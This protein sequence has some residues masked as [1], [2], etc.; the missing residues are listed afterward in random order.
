MSR[1]S[2]TCLLQV[3]AMKRI[4]SRLLLTFAAISLFSTVS[5][6]QKFYEQTPAAMRWVKKKFRKLSKDE[7]IAQLMIIRAHSNLGPEHVAEVTELIKK[8]NVGGLCFFQGGPVRQALLTNRYQSLAKTPLMISIDAE[9][10]VGMRLDSV[11]SFPRQLMMGATPDAQLIYRFGRVVGEQCKRMGIQ[12]NYAPD[13]DVNNNPLNPV[14]NDRSFGEDKYKVALYGVQYMK[15]LQDIGV[16]ATAKHFPGHGDVSVDSHKDLPVITKSRAQLDDLELYPFIELIKAGVGSIMTA[17]L[18][19]PAIDTTPNLP[20]SLSYRNVT[21]ILRNDLHFTGITFTDALEMQGVAKYFPKGDASVLSLIA[22]NDMLCLPGDIPGSIAK[23]KE[24][25]AE[26]KLSWDDIDARVKKVLLAKYHLG[27]AAWEP[28]KTENLVDDLNAQTNAIRQQVSETAL[29]LLSKQNP[30]IFPIQ[31]GRKIAYVSIGSA[32]ENTITARMRSEYGADVYLFGSKA[33]LGAQLMD[34]RTVVVSADKVDTA[35][36]MQLLNTL[37]GKNYDAVIVGL[38]NYSRRPANNYGLS[39]AVVYLVN[40]LQQPNMLTMVFGNPYAIKYIDQPSNLV[41][42]YEDDDLTQETAVKLLQG[43]IQPKGK[44]PVTVSDRLKFGDGIV[45]HDYFAPAAP[46]AVG[47]NS[48]ILL[49]IDSIASDAVEKM[50]VPGCVVLVAKDG[51][52]VY[53]KAFGYTNL[54]K[55]EP[56][57]RD[58]VY[59]LA[60]VTKISATTV[61]VMKLYEQGKI[62]INKTLGDYLP[63]ARG[64]D[65]APLKL[66][67]ILLHQA[68]LNPFIPFYREVI[69]TATGKPLPQYFTTAQDDSHQYRVAEGLY[70]RNDWQDTLYKRILKS[71]LGAPDKYV[72]SD[73]DF[74]FLGKIV[75]AVSGQ[76]LNEYVRETFYLPLNMT[77]TTFRPREL[78]PLDLI[79]PTEDEK[80]FRQ[81]LIRG[82]VHDEGSAMFGGV[83]GHAGLFS[84]AYDLAQ[85]YQML[86][87]GGELN[88]VRLLQK[89][90]VDKFTAYNSSVSHRGLGFDK[91]YKDNSTR[92][93]AYPSRSASPATFGHTGFTGTCVWVDPAY[94][95]VYIFLS[96]RV[97]PTRNNIR[98]GQ[99]NI[100]PNIQEA[101]YQAIGK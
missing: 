64:T 77:T 99:M 21:G 33:P 38:H 25:I 55:K 42:A 61:S 22:G 65:K 6:S 39:N 16:M 96:N 74:I 92:K 34:D 12:V 94:N 41:A 90:T 101:I 32:G 85:L 93:E 46:E 52:L 49:K 45:Y 75:E 62:D 70:L 9:W 80:H 56:V 11:I 100:R 27:L 89:S 84:N 2:V 19:I 10:G 73:N 95:L 29:T 60:S 68:G 87:N 18:S 50:A 81:Q 20:S 26:G 37:A 88:G 47:M 58:M 72:Y 76:P 31:Q 7:R 14:I 23:V 78:M 35:S 5:I 44:L 67:D 8:Y 83:A 69:D 17:H 28:I 4:A 59:D 98:F 36:A 82:D 63:W 48:Q 40:A 79:A 1:N 3:F 97:T 91:P 24:A 53:H 86:L 15:G 51:K 66:N 71:K 30:A 43:S 54:D 57:T 13:V